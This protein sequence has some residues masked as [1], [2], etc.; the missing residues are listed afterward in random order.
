VI[1]LLAGHRDVVETKRAERRFR[2]AAVDAFD[3]LEAEHV[4]AMRPHEALD[5]ID[6]EPD[7][8]DVPSGETEAHRSVKRRGPSPS[9]LR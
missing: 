2:K 5:E 3:L 1:A 4:G 9:A 7:R 6:P 8:V